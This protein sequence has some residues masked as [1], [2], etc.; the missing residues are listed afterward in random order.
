M[1]CDGISDETKVSPG[2]PIG[3]DMLRSR[4]EITMPNQSCIF[5]IYFSTKR[6]DS[7]G[8]SDSITDKICRWLPVQLTPD[9]HRG[10]RVV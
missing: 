1:A 4:D 6:P 2:E 10:S 7:K 3:R 9:Q 5:L 8:K